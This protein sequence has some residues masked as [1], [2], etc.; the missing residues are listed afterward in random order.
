M[1]KLTPIT[2][3]KFIKI[4]PRLGFVLVRIRGS[5]HFLENK[6]TGKIA[7]IPVHGRED[8]SIGILLAILDEIGITR[9]E[10]ERL[11]VGKK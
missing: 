10:Y 8:L 1:P 6:D 9:K 11:R 3:R 4:L 2:P 5:H 7:V